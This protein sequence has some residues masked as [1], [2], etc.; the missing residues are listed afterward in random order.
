MPNDLLILEAANLFCGDDPSGS[1]HLALTELRLPTLEHNYIDH[2][3]GG[4]PVAVEVETHIN[5]LQI[6]F[7]LAG[8]QPQVLRLMSARQQQFTIYGMLRNRRSGEPLQAIAVVQGILG[9]ASPAPFTRGVLHT[10]EY[11][12]RAIMHY[13]VSIDTDQLFY[14]DFY[15][16]RNLSVRDDNPAAFLQRQVGGGVFDI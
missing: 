5:N 1:N 15:E 14:W 8:W 16:T 4:A 11:A 10:H 9:R 12:I 6:T 3:A 2:A 13:S 7:T